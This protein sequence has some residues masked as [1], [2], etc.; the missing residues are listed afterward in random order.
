MNSEVPF[1]LTS[2]Q[3]KAMEKLGALQR[4]MVF[5]LNALVKDIERCEKTITDLKNELEVVNQK[6]QNRSTT[7]EDVDYLT[8]LLNCAK[9]KLN[10][11]RN[12][13]SLQKR[14]PPLLEKMSSMINDPLS[15]PGD[16]TRTQILQALATLQ[17]AMERL[18]NAKVV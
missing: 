14:T 4:Q 18:Q 12:M 15:P 8:D 17:E 9:K 10:W 5:E 6:H 13:A 7:R 3:L 1:M 11:E 2:K 16:E